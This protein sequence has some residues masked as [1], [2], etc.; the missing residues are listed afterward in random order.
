ME[1]SHNLTK[2]ELVRVLGTRAQQIAEGAAPL[3]D[4]DGLTTALAIAE[5]ELTERKIPIIIVRK[6]PN[7]T[8]KEIS[9]AEMNY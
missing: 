4:L 1:F 8:L 5:K 2:Y 9:V 3:V 6:L 7:G